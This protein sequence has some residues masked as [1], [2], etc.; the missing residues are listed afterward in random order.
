MVG[1]LGGLGDIA[2]LQEPIGAILR[3]NGVAKNIIKKISFAGVTVIEQALVKQELELAKEERA[4]KRN[5]ISIIK[6]KA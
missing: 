2:C 5:C 4:P 3:I 1:M 6:I